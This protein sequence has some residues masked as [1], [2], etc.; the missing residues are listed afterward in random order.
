MTIDPETIECVFARTSVG[1][2]YNF[3]AMKWA[4]SEGLSMFDP[5][6]EL[7]RRRLL[8]RTF[9]EVLATS[10]GPIRDYLKAFRDE[11]MAPGSPW[12]PRQSL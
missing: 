1:A 4:L 5:P 7:V 12:P 3:L 10:V 9:D 6:P 11:V 8:A 2:R